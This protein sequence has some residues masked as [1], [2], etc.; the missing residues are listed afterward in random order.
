[1]RYVFASE[2]SK[3]A[4]NL[5]HFEDHVLYFRNTVESFL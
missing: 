1:M 2:S 4:A 3:F 5:G